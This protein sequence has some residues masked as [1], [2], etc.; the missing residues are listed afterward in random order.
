MSRTTKSHM[1]YTG[2]NAVKQVIAII[3]TLLLCSG[4]A[5]LAQSTTAPQP[6]DN[7]AESDQTIDVN[8]LK[9]NQRD[10]LFTAAI[11]QNQSVP[12]DQVNDIKEKYA[13]MTPAQQ[14]HTIAEI[15][16]QLKNLPKETRDQILNNMPPPQ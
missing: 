1:Y 16:K 6:A 10:Y 15:A 12:A 7:S 5:A 8:N 4:S 2:A 14:L 13:K 9:P 11:N 3:A